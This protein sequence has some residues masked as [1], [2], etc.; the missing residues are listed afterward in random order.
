MKRFALLLGAAGAALFIFL[1]AKQGFAN[2]WQTVVSAGWYLPL[3]V[4]A[5]GIPVTADTLSWRSL[6]PPDQRPK[7]LQLVWLRWIREGVNHLLPTARVGGDFVRARLTSWRYVPMR[8]AAA[9]VVADLT[10]GIFTQAGFTLIGLAL[11]IAVTGT[12]SGILLPILAGVALAFGLFTGFF[13]VQR[14]GLFAL[15]GKLLSKLSRSK[16]WALLSED[17]QRLDDSVREVYSRRA[18][19]V[20]SMSWTMVS[21]ITGS[22]EVWLAMHALGHP[23]TIAEAIIIES[24]GQAVRGAS[25]MVPGALGVQ[26]GGL[27][28]I[29][30]VFG[31]PADQALAL[32][33]IKR[34][35]ELTLGAPAL[36]VWQSLEGKRLLDKRNHHDQALKPQHE[37]TTS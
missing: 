18:D 7:F 29:C 11:L 23:V 33:L 30:G 31:I 5:H 32:S 36:I 3:I 26:E 4:L 1:I 15:I 21:W 10:S 22:A 20:K 28:L 8:T 9:T 16:S 13:L 24:M 34:F 14:H 37:T 12:S 6:F 27:T 19:L 35:R 2:V 25:F 17:G